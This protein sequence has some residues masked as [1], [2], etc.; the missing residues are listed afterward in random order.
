MA[1]VKVNISTNQKIT[2]IEE[3]LDKANLNFIAEEHGL[4]TQT[5]TD[6]P[7]HKAIVRADT[8]NIL[9]VV[10]A[11][12]HPIQNSDAMAFMDTIVQ[13]KGFH[14]NEAISRDNG[15]I[16]IITAQSNTNDTI[17]VGDEV[18]RQIKLING[19][20]GKVGFAVEFSLIR[21]VCSNGMVKKE[22]EST[23]KFKHTITVNERM[24]VALQ[25]F[26]KSLSVHDDFITK[27]RYLAQKAVDRQMVEDFINGLYGESKINDNKKNKIV[28]LFE[29]GKGNQ[30]KTLWDLYQGANEYINHYH[31]K[32]EKRLEFATFGSGRKLNEKAWDL[33]VSMI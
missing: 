9:G 17:R 29:S 28:E 24:S 2:S 30:G 3:A 32:D 8:K 4:M 12:Y 23:I 33:A 18:C 13:N 1:T 6:V 11:K 14:Y 15:Q 7:T 22:K 26:D 20:N 27:S 10:G 16:S 21:L 31:G 5:G 25:V 19:F